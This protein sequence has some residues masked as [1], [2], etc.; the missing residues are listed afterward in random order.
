M[1]GE[2]GEGE[3]G[4]GGEGERARTVDNHPTDAHVRPV[5]QN[6]HVHQPVGCNHRRGGV[7]WGG[8]G[9][10]RETESDARSKNG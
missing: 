5:V 10:E 3:R 1:R 2:G 8:E 6:I 4:G 7:R 9:R